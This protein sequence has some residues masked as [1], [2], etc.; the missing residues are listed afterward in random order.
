MMA[1]GDFSPDLANQLPQ[2][3]SQV[4]CISGPW[5]SLDFIEM[6]RHSVQKAQSADDQILLAGDRP[7]WLGARGIFLHRYRKRGRRLS[8]RGETL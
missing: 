7:R 5:W 3:V 8:D 2:I 1:L 4:R 6:A